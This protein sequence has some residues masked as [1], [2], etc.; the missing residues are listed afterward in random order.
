[1]F[2]DLNPG[3]LTSMNDFPVLVKQN[4]C[5]SRCAEVVAAL[6]KISVKTSNWVTEPDA[7]LRQEKKVL[8]AGFSAAAEIC[9]AL[10]EGEAS[11]V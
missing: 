8:H 10:I 6:Q 7:Q 4:P 5:D 11:R 1:M 3:I 2:S 9:Q